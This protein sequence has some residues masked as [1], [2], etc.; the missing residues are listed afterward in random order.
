[1]S[2][3]STK[4]VDLLERGSRSDVTKGP[5]F[6]NAFDIGTSVG[7]LTVGAKSAETIF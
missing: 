7:G 6:Y 2:P 5:I 3:Q 1:M 4:S